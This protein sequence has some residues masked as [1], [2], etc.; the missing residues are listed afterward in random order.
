MNG[1]GAFLFTFVLIHILNAVGMISFDTILP[2]LLGIILF[3]VLWELL[4]LRDIRRAGERLLTILV[5]PDE[6]FPRMIHLGAAFLTCMMVYFF[7]FFNL[8]S[9][10]H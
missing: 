8:L 10:S 2:Y 7:L 6:K 4:T 1:I 5:I 9:R 3:A